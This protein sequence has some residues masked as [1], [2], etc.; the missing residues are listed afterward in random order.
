MLIT[1]SIVDTSH[2]SVLGKLYSSR[3]LCWLLDNACFAFAV[4]VLASVFFFYH[5]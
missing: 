5:D 1:Y 4:L 2:F 3:L